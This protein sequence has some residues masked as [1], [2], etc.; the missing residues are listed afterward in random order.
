MNAQRSGRSPASRHGILG[1][2]VLGLAALLLGACNGTTPRSSVTEAPA[3]AASAA[4]SATASDVASG[5][6]PAGQTDTDW[7][8]IW[9]ELPEAF[10]TYAGGTPA[11]DA[12]TEAVS[13]TVALEGVEARAVAAWMQTEL[14]RAAYRTEALN[15]PFEDGSYVLELIGPGDCRIEVDVGP[16]GGLVTVSVRYGAACAAP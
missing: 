5:E 9:D 10:P 6:P 11:D 13:G 2:P 7:G 8:R 1:L 12:S 15:G 16:L 3:S 14:E 4:P